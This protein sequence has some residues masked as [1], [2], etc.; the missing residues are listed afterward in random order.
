[1]SEIAD[2]GERLS[3]VRSVLLLDGADESLLEPGEAELL[4][5]LAELIATRELERPEHMQR[6]GEYAALLARASGLDRDESERIGL[7]AP[8]HDIGKVAVSDDI[9]FKQGELDSAEREE[10]QRHA[11]A[12]HDLLDDCSS[13]VLLLAAEIALTH[14]E[15][16]AGGGYPRGI[17]GEEI[18]IAGRIVA[19]ADVFDALVCNRPYRRALTLEQTVQIMLKARGEHFDPVLLDNFV[20]ELDNVL[21]VAARTADIDL[22]LT[23]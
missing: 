20:D 15:R 4:G 2:A 16:F 14:H 18:P 8:L 7:A 13:D 3:K 23:L 1:M 5:R 22:A 21:A 10:M 6:I 9:L 17:A 11:Q 12:G 19:V